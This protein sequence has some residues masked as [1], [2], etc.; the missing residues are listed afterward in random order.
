MKAGSAERALYKSFEILNQIAEIIWI[1][2][3]GPISFFVPAPGLFP[4]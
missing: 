3:A 2:G 4:A 1:Y